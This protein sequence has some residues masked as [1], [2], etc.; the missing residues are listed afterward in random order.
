MAAIIPAISKAMMIN[1]QKYFCLVVVRLHKN[2]E[3]YSYYKYT[4]I[5]VN[6]ILIYIIELDR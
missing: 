1:V 5:S 3:I 6:I 2:K 4:I